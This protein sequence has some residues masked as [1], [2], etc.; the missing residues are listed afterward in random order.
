MLN[1]EYDEDID[2][3]SD[4][5]GKLR[6]IQPYGVAAICKGQ[7][8]FRIANIGHPPTNPSESDPGICN[9][10]ISFNSYKYSSSI[11]FISHFE[12]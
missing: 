5:L 12:I 2:E 3:I 4:D 9:L 8:H 1:T 10:L 7:L 6:G 11:F